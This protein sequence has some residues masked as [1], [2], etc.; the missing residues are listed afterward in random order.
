MTLL[1]S[2]DVGLFHDPALKSVALVALCSAYIQGPIVKI[3]DFRSAIEE[4][5]RFRL[6]PA[7]L[8]AVIVIIFELTASAL[9]ISGVF[10]WAASL[11]L[12]AFT[13]LATGLT[14]RFWEL[15][16]GADRSAA[17]NAFFEHLGL[18]AAFVL[19][20]IDSIPEALTARF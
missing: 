7:P 5:V 8:F 9:V 11:A 1:G 13:L 4:M 6:R 14:L 10:R 2:Q 17:M 18:V 15:P 16:K 3:F 20:A 12:A 19:V